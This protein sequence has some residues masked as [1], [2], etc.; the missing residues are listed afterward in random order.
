MFRL[1]YAVL[2]TLKLC[3]QLPY[4][5]KMAGFFF[6]FFAQIYINTLSLERKTKVDNKGTVLQT[7]QSIMKC[8]IKKETSK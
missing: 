1:N 8:E 6:F 3:N 2:D 4:G 7:K 5:L